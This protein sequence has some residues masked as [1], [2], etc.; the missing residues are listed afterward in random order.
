MEMEWS[1]TGT[2]T[3]GEILLQAMEMASSDIGVESFQVWIWNTTGFFPHC[4]GQENV[5]CDID[6][7]LWPDSAQRHDA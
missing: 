6:K 3:V 5:A 4:L 2:A 1:M 7:V